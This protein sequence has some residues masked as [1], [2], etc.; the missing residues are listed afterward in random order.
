LIGLIVETAVVHPFTN[1]ILELQRSR[2]Y[3]GRATKQK[4]SFDAEV[5]KAGANPSPG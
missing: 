4:I 2:S 1:A 5:A 3:K